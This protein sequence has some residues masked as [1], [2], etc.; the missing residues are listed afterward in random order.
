MVNLIDGPHAVRI[1][2]RQSVQL[3][4]MPVYAALQIPAGVYCAGNGACWLVF[5]FHFARELTRG[6]VVVEQKAEPLLR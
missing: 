5:N 6:W 2:P 4:H 1:K 3:V